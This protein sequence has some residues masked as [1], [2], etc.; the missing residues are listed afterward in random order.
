MGPSGCAAD[1]KVGQVRQ[2]AKRGSVEYPLDAPVREDVQN[3]GRGAY[4]LR[5][6]CLRN[7]VNQT[8]FRHH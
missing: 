4:V 6:T 3:L 1:G 5:R 2:H 7:G 8:Y